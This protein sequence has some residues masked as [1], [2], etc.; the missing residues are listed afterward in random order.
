MNL[1]FEIEELVGASPRSLGSMEHFSRL[2]AAWQH[3][4]RHLNREKLQ[5]RE[6]KA[7]ASADSPEP[8]QAA[9]GLPPPKAHVVRLGAETLSGTLRMDSASDCQGVCAHSSPRRLS[10]LRPR[11]AQCSAGVGLRA[12]VEHGGICFWLS[13]A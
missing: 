2:G 13:M 11:P 3:S 4:T 5:P 1:A 7:H 12:T 9:P 6:V 8:S 10:V